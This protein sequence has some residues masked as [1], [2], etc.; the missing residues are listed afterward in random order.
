[1]PRAAMHVRTGRGRFC[2]RRRRRGGRRSRLDATDWRD[3][4][5]AMSAV[6]RTLERDP[7]GIYA[8]MDFAT[9]D[10]YRHVVEAIAR[11]SVR[12]ENDVARAAIAL[13]GGADN[14]RRAHVGYHLIADGRRDLE[15]AVGMRAGLIL[16]APLPTSTS[17]WCSTPSRRVPPRQLRARSP[18]KYILDVHG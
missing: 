5:E 8:A 14:D 16:A 7:A 17:T 4:V 10:A 2:R 18:P 6:E 12:D 9:R 11:R 1:M 13:A 3:F 15:R